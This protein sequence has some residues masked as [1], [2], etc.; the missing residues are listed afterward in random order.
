MQDSLYILIQWYPECTTPKKTYIEGGIHEGIDFLSQDATRPDSVASRWSWRIVPWMKQQ[1]L[2][3]KQCSSSTHFLKWRTKSHTDLTRWGHMHCNWYW[4]IFHTYTYHH[5]YEYGCFCFLCFK[6]TFTFPYIHVES[7]GRCRLT[8]T[9]HLFGN[10]S[11][12]FV[13]IC[14]AEELLHQWLALAKIY[15]VTRWLSWNFVRPMIL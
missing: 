15:L 14:H 3:V 4:C 9:R 7:T 11:I 12:T 13:G 2:E 8:T 6:H 10:A 5:I 1:G